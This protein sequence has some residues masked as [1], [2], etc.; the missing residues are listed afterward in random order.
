MRLRQILFNVVGNALKFT[1][2]GYVKIKV[3]AQPCE[4][5]KPNQ[6]P[7]QVN[8]EIQVEDT[9]IGIAPEQQERIFEL[10]IQ[11]DGQSTRKYGGTGLGLAI[12]K[13]L[14]NLLG[15][16]VQLTSELGKGSIFSFKFSQVKVLESANAIN[17]IAPISK[18]DEDLNQFKPA[19]IL[20]VDDV[21]SNL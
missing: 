2:Q 1:E 10:F 17:A 16:T 20:V 14:T 8:L 9:G 21:K 13:R 18:L 12:T 4:T 5:S 11:S 7:N 19:T 3:N 15:G 6:I